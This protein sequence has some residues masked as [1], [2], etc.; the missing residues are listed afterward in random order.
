[1]SSPYLGNIML[2]AGTFPPAGWAFCD[3]QHLPIS[4][5][6]ELFDLIGTRYGGDGQESFALPDLRGRVPIHV[7]NGHLL[8]SSGGADSVT[9]TTNQMPAH[10]HTMLG[11]GIVGNDPNPTGNMVAESSAM[12]LYQSASPTVPLAAQMAGTVGNNQ[13]HDNM[14]PYTCLNY[15]IS[16][17]GPE[18]TPA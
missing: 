10:S 12:S 5:N 3:G 13:P 15:V 2:F 6:Q 16:L 1:M 8:A 18:P 7:G 11:A 14:Q 17:Y 9:L 4:E